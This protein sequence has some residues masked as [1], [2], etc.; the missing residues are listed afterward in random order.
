[1]KTHNLLLA[2]SFG[3]ILSAV[4]A[5][6]DLPDPGMKVDMSNT[7]LVVTDPQNDFL[8]PQGV[9]QSFE[10]AVVTNAP[11]CNLVIET[12]KGK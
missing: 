7:A 6:A 10:V 4:T 3:L 12:Y 5:S 8:S 9:A 1:M 2:S 11:V